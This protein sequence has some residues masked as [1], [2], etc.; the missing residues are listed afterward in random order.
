M[1]ALKQQISNITMLH[2]EYLRVCLD[3]NYK[4]TIKWLKALI[5]NKYN[6]DAPNVPLE[7]FNFTNLFH[8][9]SS[10]KYVQNSN[11]F[12]KVYIIDNNDAKKLHRLAKEI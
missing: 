2:F 3:Y 1:Q 11:K 7:K 4:K 10:S 6:I 5:S 9:N 12:T 8:K